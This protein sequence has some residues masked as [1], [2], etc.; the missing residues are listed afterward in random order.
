MNLEKAFAPC[1]WNLKSK[2]I[3]SKI[4]KGVFKRCYRRD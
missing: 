1:G 4:K 2:I 3:K